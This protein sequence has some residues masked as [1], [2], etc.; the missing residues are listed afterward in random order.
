MHASSD[1]NPGGPGVDNSY[2]AYVQIEVTNCGARSLGEFPQNHSWLH[3]ILYDYLW[4][5]TVYIGLLT[6]TIATLFSVKLLRL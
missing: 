3:V 2:I 4:V 1:I 6:I 5:L